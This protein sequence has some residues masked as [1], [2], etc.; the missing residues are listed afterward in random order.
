MVENDN[1]KRISRTKN[2]KSDYQILQTF[3]FRIFSIRYLFE[4]SLRMLQ[5]LNHLYKTRQNKVY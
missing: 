5:I 2:F 3:H 4:F 1:A